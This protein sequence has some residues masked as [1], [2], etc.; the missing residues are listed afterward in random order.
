MGVA[1]VDEHLCVSHNGTGIC[2]ACHTVC[3]LRNRAIEQ[4]YRN[5]PI[6]HADSCTGCGLCEEVCIVDERSGVR[7]IQVQS[8]RRLGDDR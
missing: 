6:V 5:A 1:V 8:E 7:A 3:P 2:G 4:D